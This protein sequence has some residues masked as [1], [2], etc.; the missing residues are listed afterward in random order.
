MGSVGVFRVTKISNVEIPKQRICSLKFCRRYSVRFEESRRLFDFV[1][2]DVVGPGFSSVASVHLQPGQTVYV[3]HNQREM[4]G[5]VV[6]HDFFAQ[7]VLITV[8]NISPENE[9]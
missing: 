3:T 9:R 8:N 1:E 4:S 7:D 5:R 6:R 2:K